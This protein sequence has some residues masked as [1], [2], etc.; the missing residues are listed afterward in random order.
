MP[1]FA[2]ELQAA[3]VMLMLMLM[4]VGKALVVA[5]VVAV[6]VGVAAAAVV[7]A[8]A[9]VA[10]AG[11]V[12]VARTCVL[13]TRCSCR[14]HPLMM[15]CFEPST[16]QSKLAVGVCLFVC[17]FVYVCCWFV[18]LCVC[19]GGGVSIACLAG[20]LLCARCSFVCGLCAELA[21]IFSPYNPPPLLARDAVLLTV[22]RRSDFMCSSSRGSA[23]TRHQSLTLPRT[24]QLLPQLCD[25]TSAS[26]NVTRAL[27]CRPKP[28]PLPSRAQAPRASP[29]SRR[30]GTF[31]HV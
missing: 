16:E 13:C 4:V 17:L 9:V 6:V 20:L 23:P 29:C 10:G 7:A 24:W 31:T 5:V 25:R 2:V 27:P 3:N 8:V 19:V 28:A 12:A 14:A 21:V 1:A 26:S 18:S 11:A 15:T 22:G 30:Q